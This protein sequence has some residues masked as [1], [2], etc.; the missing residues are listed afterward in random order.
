MVAGGSGRP[1]FGSTSAWCC[2]NLLGHVTRMSISD[3]NVLV[4]ITGV[5]VA[6]FFGL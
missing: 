4:A 6:F 5:V 2:R 3:G 1:V